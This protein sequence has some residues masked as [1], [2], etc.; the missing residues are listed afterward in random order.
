MNFIGPTLPFAHAQWLVRRGADGVLPRE[1]TAYPRPS[2]VWW[3]RINW[4]SDI[5]ALDDG[6]W[7]STISMRF[8]GDDLESTV[9]VS[10]DDNGRH[11]SYLSTIALVGVGLFI[12]Y[13]GESIHQIWSWMMMALTAGVVVPNVLRWYWWR[14]NGWGYASGT[15]GGVILALIV[16]FVPE[17]PDYVVFPAIVGASLL[18]AIVVSLATRPTPRETLIEFYRSIRPFGAWGPVRRESGLSE[19][20]LAVPSERAGRA[21]LNTLLGIVAITGAYLFPMYLVGHWYAPATI[22]LSALAG[23]AVVLYFTWYRYLPPRG[24]K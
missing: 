13:H 7:I 23:A 5:L 17:A 21:V 24:E 2:R 3:A 22:C 14:T 8:K 16:F 11:W 18:T 6:R 20:E 10:S 1:V 12:G 19:V 15:L 9:A 4:F